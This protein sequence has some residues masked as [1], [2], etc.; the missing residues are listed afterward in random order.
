MFFFGKVIKVHFFT[1]LIEIR[2]IFMIFEGFHCNFK[3]M[4]FSLT[5]NNN[6]IGMRNEFDP[7][8]SFTVK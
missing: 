5:L 1:G 7:F 8:L 2:V 6:V 3:E 4:M